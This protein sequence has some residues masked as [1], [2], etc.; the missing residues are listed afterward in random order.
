MVAQPPSAGG[1]QTAFT[2]SSEPQA[3]PPK[4]SARSKY[5]EDPATPDVA[6]WMDE[7]EVSGA[8]VECYS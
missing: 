3:V 2:Y 4:R 8:P 5:R 7:N 6:Q 1:S